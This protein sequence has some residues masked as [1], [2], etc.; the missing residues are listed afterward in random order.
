M[1]KELLKTVSLGDRYDIQARLL[2]GLI[3]VSPLF[4]LISSYYGDK[5][6]WLDAIMKAGGVELIIGV[7]FSKLARLLGV[8]YE[9]RLV[10]DWGG[11]PATQ[12]LLPGDHTHSEQVK[13]R[14]RQALADLSG[15]EL[16]ETQGEQ[17]EGEQKRV[18][19]DAIGSVRNRIRGTKE[20]E[21]LH[22]QNI[23]YGFARNLG[24]LRRLLVP[25]S[26]LCSAGSAFAA[27]QG[28]LPYGVA[29]IQAC[30]F[31]FVAI[32]AVKASAF[33]KHCAARYAEAFFATISRVAQAEKSPDEK[34]R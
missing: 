27:W 21:F 19:D 20:A 1:M 14:W 11:L 25:L 34:S 7:A 18:I 26:L 32:Y 22:R 30:V 17:D 15:L 2:P 4:V 3:A 16:D 13:V 9:N 31:L 28:L 24:G 12:W 33:V 23:E 8:A 10:R 5:G 29:G 6:E